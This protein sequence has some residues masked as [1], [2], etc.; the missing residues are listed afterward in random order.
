V[1]ESEPRVERLTI[2]SV[3]GQLRDARTW[4]TRM[5]VGQGW[6]DA[7]AGDLAVVL[8]EACS[9]AIRHG[10]EERDD[11]RIDL[12]LRLDANAVELSVR[13]YGKGFDPGAYRAPDLRQ[14]HVGG[15]GIHLMNQL[16]DSVE[17]RP[18]ERGTLVVMTKTRSE[19][20]EVA[21]VR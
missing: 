4:L 9:N 5:L 2:R 21:H 8:S 11:G 6:A 3:P 12:E 13:D 1:P 18:V 17:L 14:P 16:A 10:Y 15:Y 7:E 19:E 20:T